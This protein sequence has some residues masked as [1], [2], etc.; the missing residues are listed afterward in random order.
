[1]SSEEIAELIAELGKT[2]RVWSPIVQVMS[3]GGHPQ[4][5]QAS[6]AVLEAKGWPKE[7]FV[8]LLMGTP[9]IE[10]ERA[11]ARQRLIEALPD[12]MRALLYRLS[13][14]VGQMDRGLVLAVAEVEP[15]VERPGEALEQLIG[16][17]VER[18]A[19]NQLRVSPLVANAGIQILGPAEIA[20]VRHQ[21]VYFLMRGGKINVGDSDTIL[22]HALTGKVE[23]ALPRIGRAVVRANET[24]LRNLA[25]HFVTLPLLR[26]DAPIYPDN[27]FISWI[28]RLAQ[29]TL[30]K[31]MAQP[32]AFEQCLRSLLRETEDLGDDLAERLARL[33]VLG[34]VLIEKQSAAVIPT[35]I[36]LLLEY[37]DLVARSQDMYRGA[38]RHV[39]DKSMERLGLGLMFVVQ[40][41][42]TQEVAALTYVFDR[43]DSLDQDTRNA[44]FAAVDE[45]PG[46]LSMM[47]NPA[48]LAEAER[49]SLVWSDAA[50]RLG[51]MADQAGGWGRRELSLRC[52]TARAVMADEYGKQPETALAMLDEATSLLGRDPILA[53]ARA[54][55]LWRKKRSRRSFTPSGTGHC[56][57]TDRRCDRKG[58]HASGSGDLRGGSWRLDSRAGMVLGRPYCCRCGP[59]G[60]NAGH[61]DWHG[62]GRRR[63]QYTFGLLPRCANSARRVH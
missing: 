9:E 63:G 33:I 16:P 3:G 36:D 37:R 52:H 24:V 19:G 18:L 11:I 59:A 25:D 58:V 26:T 6:V 55:I 15:V 5:V 54:K 20:A 1:M 41:L 38:G 46:K 29:F 60:T 62:H 43:L 44:I 21:I 12:A 35:W 47:V 13:I 32:R 40:C 22:L 56:G 27:F 57:A 61:V 8:N 48:W 10:K 17:W 45:V 51:R 53:R 2:V 7:E 28:L 34:K 49:H 30:L 39:P 42:G 31:V 14:I 23:W 50:S 4:L